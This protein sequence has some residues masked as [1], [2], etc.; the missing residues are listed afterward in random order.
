MIPAFFHA[1]ACTVPTMA[2]TR[3]VITAAPMATMATAPI[4]KP[5]SV[6]LTA[7]FTIMV[8]ASIDVRSVHAL[9]VAC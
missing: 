7:G 4:V 3:M 6:A 8:A 2:F 1:R 5:P 9:M